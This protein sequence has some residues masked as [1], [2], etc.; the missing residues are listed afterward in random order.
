M[1]SHALWVPNSIHTNLA[2]CRSPIDLAIARALSMN[3]SANGLRVRPLTVMTPAAKRST[4]GVIHDH[5]SAHGGEPFRDRRA[6]ALGG[7]SHDRHLAR[8][9]AHV[10]SPVLPTFR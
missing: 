4:G 7:A 9:L 5:R 6:D 8:Q 3:S 2:L 10:N 1:K